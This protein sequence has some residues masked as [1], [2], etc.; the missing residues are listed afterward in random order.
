MGKKKSY[1]ELVKNKKVKEKS[2]P[3]EYYGVT[4]DGLKFYSCLGY[5]DKMTDEPLEECARCEHYT[6]NADETFKRKTT[7]LSNALIV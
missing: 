7:I 4:L 6:A 5:I 2:L 3:G 1:C